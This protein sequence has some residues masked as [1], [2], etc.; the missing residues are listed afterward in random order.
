MSA[1]PQQR[2]EKDECD[3]ENL[4]I[5]RRKLLESWKDQGDF[6]EGLACELVDFIL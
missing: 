5:F 3:E 4:W 1:V 6:K 2:S